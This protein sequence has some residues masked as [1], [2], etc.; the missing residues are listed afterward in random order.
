MHY[1]R[2]WHVNLWSVF[3]IIIPGCQVTSVVKGVGVTHLDSLTLV[4]ERTVE[5]GGDDG[6]EGVDH[7]TL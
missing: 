6:H 7:I 5:E 1:M 2:V 4:W 3:N